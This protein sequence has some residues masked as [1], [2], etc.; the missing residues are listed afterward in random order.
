VSAAAGPTTW[1]ILS[2]V[3]RPPVIEA[4]PDG[5]PYALGRSI[6]GVKVGLEVDYAWL[7]YMTLIDEWEQL[8]RADGAEPLTLW[9]E[10]SRD[11]PERDPNEVRAQVEEW[12]KLID[13]GVVGLGN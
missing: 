7:C 2:P 6:A 10:R 3:A 9:V 1:T 12:S 13:C 4:E 5:G 11:A 8:L